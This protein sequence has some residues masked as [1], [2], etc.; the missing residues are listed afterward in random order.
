MIQQAKPKA[1][2]PRLVLGAVPGSKEWLIPR[3]SVLKLRTFPQE[4]QTFILWE[5][6]KYFVCA[7][8]GDPL[9]TL[10]DARE[11]A[12]LREMLTGKPQEETEA[13]NGL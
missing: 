7:K 11:N 13:D 10:K 12:M 1:R 4:A 8:P 3:E 5:G 6:I 9:P 2:R